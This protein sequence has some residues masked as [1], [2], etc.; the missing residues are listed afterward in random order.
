MLEQLTLG[1]R[2]HDTA[3]FDSFFA[4]NNDEVICSL[5]KMIEIPIWN[6]IYIYGNCNVG[7]SHLLQACC[8]YASCQQFMPFYLPLS[9]KF[10]PSIL[11]NLDNFS[12]VCIDNIETIAGSPNWE[13]ALFHFYNRST[14]K[15]TRIIIAGDH[16]PS[17]L[18]FTLPALVSRL[19]SGI[20]YM[21]KPL[22]DKQ[23]LAALQL[24]AT[25]RGLVLNE[26]VGQYLLN[27]YPRD[28]SALFGLLDILDQASLEARH[29]LTVPFV[30][31]VLR[32]NITGG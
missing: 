29:R 20:I 8:H 21:I 13:E 27:H 4:G 18:S 25:M 2:L 30:K 9:S 5:K 16:V 17:Q 31:S 24:R 10:P 32:R 28:M 14:Q 3:N 12:L 23:K 26:E 7:K 6:Y 1:I 22:D 11:E 19:S 15:N